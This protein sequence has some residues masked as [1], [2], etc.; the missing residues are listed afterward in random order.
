MLHAVSVSSNF[1]Q[2]PVMFE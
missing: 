1:I 2:S